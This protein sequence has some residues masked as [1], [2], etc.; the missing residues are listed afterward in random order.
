MSSSPRVA[1]S[2]PTEAAHGP[3]QEQVAY[4]G[5]PDNGH[6]I[7]DP[8]EP[9]AY[10]LRVVNRATEPE[11][12]ATDSVTVGRGERDANRNREIQRLAI[13]YRSCHRSSDF[14]EVVLR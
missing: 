9:G 2:W 1:S 11:V 8:M 13:R 4:R 10:A 7:V 6:W 12:L 14:A 5:Y 3:D